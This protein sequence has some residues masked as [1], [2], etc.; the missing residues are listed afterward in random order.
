M[1]H[2]KRPALETTCDVL[3]RDQNNQ[4]YPLAIQSF[5]AALR[6]SPKDFHSWIGLGEAYAS[7]G[8]YTA[9]LKVFDRAAM[10]DETNWFAKY[11]LANVRRELGEFESA[12][13]G[14]RE[15]LALREREFGVLVALSETLVAMAWKYLE[16]GYY[17]RAVDSVAE[18]MGV[19]KRVLEE[20]SDTFNLWKTVGDA[21]MVFSWVQDLAHLFPLTQVLQL[22]ED[23]FDAS[24]LDIMADADGVGQ[25]ALDKL[26]GGGVHVVTAPV[27]AGILAYKRAIFATA[28]DRHAHAVAWY[29][30]G[31]AEHRAYVAL[32]PRDMK[33]RLAA[34][35]CFKRTI[36]L[37]PGNHEFWNALGSATAEL[38]PKVAQHSLV[39]A[40][41]INDKVS[42]SPP[43]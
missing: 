23:D 22:I 38:N 19:A 30:L 13:E 31:T 14:Y 1:S 28:D 15:V 3:T 34:I 8:R 33:H 11:M 25:P 12:C 21:C 10:L 35:R 39:R 29:N 5:Q 17:G 37:E 24:E 6:G 9:A 20:R 2:K 32:T 27:Y 40:L 4:N 41:Y 36:K 16:T 18:C 42:F 7:A 43:K 26:K